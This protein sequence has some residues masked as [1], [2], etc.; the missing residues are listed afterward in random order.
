MNLAEIKAIYD[1]R[2]KSTD[3]ESL[4]KIRTSIEIKVRETKTEIEQQLERNN[5]KEALE[6]YKTLNVF[7]NDLSG[8][9][10]EIN[11]HFATV[12]AR[13]EKKFNE[14]YNIFNSRFSSTHL[15]I[16]T[17]NDEMEACVQT[18]FDNL[19]EFSKFKFELTGEKF[20]ILL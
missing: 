17:I 16:F 12:K 20:F 6:N 3:H 10:K 19:I 7:R 15:C 1:E 14:I 8:S 5:I 13:V 2:K 4:K 11:N 9:F 18:S